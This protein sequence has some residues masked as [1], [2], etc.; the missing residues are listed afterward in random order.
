LRDADEPR[1]PNFCPSR[2][3]GFMQ[4]DDYG[5]DEEEEFFDLTEPVT[6]SR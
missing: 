5:D 6:V 2:L 3:N 4:S 1:R